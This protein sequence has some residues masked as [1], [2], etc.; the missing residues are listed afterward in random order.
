MSKCELTLCK[1]KNKNGDNNLIKHFVIFFKYKKT[2]LQ[3]KGYNCFYPNV[4]TFNIEPKIK[5][6]NDLKI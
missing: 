3:S 6:I 2:K 4:C 5:D 1:R